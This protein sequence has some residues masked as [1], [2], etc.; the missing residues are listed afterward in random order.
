MGWDGMGWDGM[1]WDGMGWHDVIP[2]LG[3]CGCLLTLH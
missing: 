1:G 3:V 2:F